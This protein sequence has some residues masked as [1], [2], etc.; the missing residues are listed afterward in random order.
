MS[1][2]HKYQACIIQFIR[3]VEPRE[4]I[5]LIEPVKKQAELLKALDLKATFLLQYDALIDQRYVDIINEN[6]IGN[7]DVGLWLEVVEPQ[8]KAAGIPWTGR[9]PWDFHAHCGFLVGYSPEDRIKLIDTAFSMFKN[10]FGHYPTAAGSWVVDAFSLGYMKEKYGIKASCNCRDQWGMDGY[11]LWGGYFNGGYYPSKVNAI[12]PASSKENQLELPVFRMS[13]SDPVFDYDTDLDYYH[14]KQEFSVPLTTMEAG[15]KHGGAN[16]HWMNWMYSVYTDDCSFPFSMAQMGQENSFGWNFMRDGIDLQF[17]FTAKLKSEGAADV[18]TLTELGENFAAEHPRSP[19][20]A[21]TARDDWR[22]GGRNCI[23]YCTPDY[24]TNVFF[25][26]GV[27]WFRDIHFYNDLYKERYL[28]EHTDLN[29]FIF[30]ALPM[31]EG[32]IWSDEEHRNGMFICD[33]ETGEVMTCDTPV[34]QKSGEEINIT[35]S[36]K[37]GK[38]AEVRLCSDRIQIALGEKLCL[39]NRWIH[40]DELPAPFIKVEDGCINASHNGFD[41]RILLSHGN[42]ELRDNSML[43]SP[44]SLGKIEISQLR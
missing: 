15:C 4:E 33:A 21:L 16:P 39:C 18:V 29:T 12:C 20:T 24:R 28:T 43:L 31:V 17:N 13:G 23:W 35:L 22:G 26:D 8:C 36:F 7:L 2:M 25:E 11:T 6:N 5:D 19:V 40:S 27:F 37:G 30:D 1:K 14:I 38:S 34:I 10:K 3:A 9:W 32:R 42:A 41:Y 44:D